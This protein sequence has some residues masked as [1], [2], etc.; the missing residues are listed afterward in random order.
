MPAEAASIDSSMTAET[1]TNVPSSPLL[2]PSNPIVGAHHTAPSPPIDLRHVTSSSALSPASARSPPTS[3]GGNRSN[4]VSQHYPLGSMSPGSIPSSP[5]SVHSSSSAIFE[6]DIEP[7]PT[8]PSNL[9]SPQSHP[10]HTHHSSSHPPNPH[11]IARGHTTESL[12]QSVPS[13]LDSAAE[14]LAHMQNGP[15][16]GDNLIVESPVAPR[17]RGGSRD[18]RSSGWASPRS[19]GSYRSR[20]PSPFG[21]SA[22]QGS[23]LLS[24]PSMPGQGSPPVTS[25]IL[26]ATA[27]S[28]LSTSPSPPRPQLPP[29]RHSTLRHYR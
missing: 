10:V 13:V 29:L 22:G 16:G 28:P 6:R 21:S 8:S 24:I 23:L 17:G 20:S 4:R 14:I 18:G 1:K 26:N 19:V 7:L 15:G 27:A 9:L 25:S 3:A 12:E 2:P 11:H 5:T